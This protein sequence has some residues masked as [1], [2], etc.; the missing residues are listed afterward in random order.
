MILPNPKDALHRGK[1][2]QLLTEI[3]DNQFLVNSLV[4]KG[5]TCAALMGKLD[6]FSIDLDFD[7]KDRS[8]T[9]EI[10]NNLDKIIDTLGLEIKS[11]HTK[12]MQYILK[13]QA[14]TE[15]RNTLKVD[16]I[17]TAY[18]ED[19]YKPVFLSDIDRYVV[20]Q[21]IETM[22]SHKLVALTERYTK[23]QTVAGRDI[24][25]IHSFF[26]NGFK[27]DPKIIE[28]GTGMPIGKYMNYLV[29]FIENHV[30]QTLINEDLNSL[31][32]SHQL[33]W[34]RKSLKQE[35]LS[36]VRNAKIDRHG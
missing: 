1:L 20:C 5:G 10:G 12:Y 31:L 18:K 24:Y 9:D 30:D 35:V 8:N 16:A 3:A 21:T 19:K 2:Y 17:N 15:Q 32:E 22:F 6:R 28:A 13:Y 36:L 27:Y 33:V 34:A 23:H 26:I 7:I 25:D 29:E 11:K 14:P 4:F